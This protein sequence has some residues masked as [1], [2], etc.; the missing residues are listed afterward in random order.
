MPTI[1]QRLV[2]CFTLAFPELSESDIRRASPDTVSDWDSEMF[3]TL[4]GIVEE[5]F[6][7]AVGEAD[8]IELLSFESYLGYLQ[9]RTKDNA[10]NVLS[11][12]AR[13]SSETN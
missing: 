1:E 5:E 11:L 12:D 13:R 4:L 9:G 7:C 10:F 8:M 6:G 2:K 3:F